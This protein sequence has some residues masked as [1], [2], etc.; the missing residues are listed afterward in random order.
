MFITRKMGVVDRFEP[1][2]EEYLLYDSN[3]N[4]IKILNKTGAY[5]WSLIP[6][7]EFINV[8]D[9][10]NELNKKFDTQI[11][12]EKIKEDTKLFVSDLIKGE[13]VVAREQ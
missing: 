13:V 1:E 5:I 11:G 12:N 7:N 8:D 4:R 3:K 6:D 2:E 10:T 9:I